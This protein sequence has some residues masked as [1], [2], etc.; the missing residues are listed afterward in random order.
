M[1]INASKFLICLESKV[2]VTVLS[3]IVLN[4]RVKLLCIFFHSQSQ[5][6]NNVTAK[7]IVQIE[8]GTA[9]VSVC[10]V[11]HL[12]QKIFDKFWVAFCQVGKPMKTAPVVCKGRWARAGSC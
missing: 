8:L 9:T 5:M 7:I 10:Y 2:R 3:Q 4:K 12:I 11:E 1:Q 6:P